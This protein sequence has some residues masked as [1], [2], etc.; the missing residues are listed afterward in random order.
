M[1]VVVENGNVMTDVKAGERLNLAV[2]LKSPETS[3][4]LNV[5]L[6]VNLTK[7]AKVSS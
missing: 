2:R 6:L 4:N 7:K 1:I 5:A 3:T